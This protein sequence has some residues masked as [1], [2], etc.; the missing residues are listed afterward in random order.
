M[1]KC[2]HNNQGFEEYYQ[3]LNKL[4][5]ADRGFYKFL[6]NCS[7]P[8]NTAASRIRNDQFFKRMK[9]KYS[10]TLVTKET[11]KKKHRL[12]QNQKKETETEKE[13]EKEKDTDDLFNNLP[14]QKRRSKRG[15]S[16]FKMDGDHSRKR[17]NS[18]KPRKQ[19]K[20]KKTGKEIEKKKRKR[21]NFE[22]PKQHKQK[23]EKASIS[24]N[25]KKVSKHQKKKINKIKAKTEP[26]FKK[27][28]SFS[29]NINS[30]SE[31][32]SDK[33]NKF[34]ND[35]QHRLR[36]T[37]DYK[38]WCWDK[39]KAFDS[40]GINNNLYYFRFN[41]PSEKGKFG[42]LSKEEEMLFVRRMK[43]YGLNCGWGNFSKGIPGRVGF[44]CSSYFRDKL[45]CDDKFSKL[46]GE[47]HER[48]DGKLNRI[49]GNR[50]YWHKFRTEDQQESSTL[51][52]RER[53]RK[54]KDKRRKEKRR[55]KRIEKKKKRLKNREKRRS[56]KKI[57]K[58]KEKEKEKEKEKG[59]G[60]G[61][62]NNQIENSHQ[63]TQAQSNTNLKEKVVSAN[64]D[65]NKKEE[66][67]KEEQQQDLTEK[68]IVKNEQESKTQSKKV[69]VFEKKGV[70]TEDFGNESKGTI[71]NYEKGATHN[72]K[73]NGGVTE[74]GF[75]PL[76]LPKYVKGLLNFAKPDEYINPLPGFIDQITNKEVK[77]P[78]LSPTGYVFDYDTWEKVLKIKPQN[79]CP[80]TRC[81]VFK[82]Q[83]IV[84]TMN[85]IEKYF[86]DIVNINSDD[87]HIK[88]K[89][90]KFLNK[91][92]EK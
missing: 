28:P 4:R 24:K 58:R 74:Y 26:N 13:K 79:C 15:V 91:K 12:K 20:E 35:K 43:T 41:H 71:L 68:V 67:H 48:V 32:G 80:I 39:Q 50:K 73:V 47:K 29:N 14:S 16:L 83:L 62:R 5:P 52:N 87:F 85:N 63:K 64:I 36:R 65:E 34:E 40:F 21:K 57:E 37:H 46:Y 38:G 44:N 1:N 59:K 61:R 33:E 54:T 53:E 70:G 18:E 19:E 3:K 42:R 72:N 2:K 11:S 31:S 69:P 6:Y 78:T 17:K 30:K 55:G 27:A 75:V 90:K 51:K 66:D 10:N 60:K 22:E 88:K 56:E 49:H 23:K 9:R 82:R 86:S 92:N 7:N 81:I 8:I 25:S 89:S 76:K 77:R 84:L 45:L